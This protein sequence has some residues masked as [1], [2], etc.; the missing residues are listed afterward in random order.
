MADV[1][2]SIQLAASVGMS[3]NPED[4]ILTMGEIAMKEAL[5]QL[6]TFLRAPGGE[7]LLELEKKLVRLFAYLSGALIAFTVQTLSRPDGSTA[8]PIARV[9]DGGSWRHKGFR[10][11]KVRFL[12]GFVCRIHTPYLVQ[13]HQGRKRGVGRRGR[14][15]GGCY[16]E[17][18]ALGIRYG[19]SPGLQSAIA[20]Q[21]VRGASFEETREV[22]FEQGDAMNVKTIRRIALAVADG[23]ITQRQARIEAAG[24]EA[25]HTNEFTGQRVVIG[26][27]GGRVRI[28]EGGDRGRRRANGRRGFHAQWREPKLFSVHVIDDDGR[29]VRHLQPLYE[30]TM[31]GPGKTFELLVAEMKLRGISKVKEVIIV[32]DG[33]SWIWNRT[34]ELPS[35]L[36]VPEEKVTR[37]ADLYHAVEHLHSAAQS[38]S[39]W[40][41][42]DVQRWVKIRKRFLLQ[43]RVD[44]VI[45]DMRSLR[46]GRNRRVIRRE[47]AYFQRL[48]PFMR[49]RFYKAHAIPL[50]SGATESA[51]RRVVNLRLKG[52]GIFW[53]RATAEMMLHLRA[54]L[55][56]RRWDE[57]MARVINATPHGRPGFVS[58]SIW[59]LEAAA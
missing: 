6:R 30:A 35:L 31:Q 28:R 46:K 25:V 4:A 8:R 20:R 27:D 10:D 49:Y 14:A 58:E 54:Y 15:G 3:A 18:E 34:A 12:G 47:S 38:R 40:A 1:Y 24:A 45:A 50:G 11:T 17:L 29:P 53:K 2:P 22:F 42:D 9:S 51:I 41:L 13:L 26:V 23:A 55:K 37:V 16:P 21:A 48:A 43:G 56:A 32:A 39:D 19:A 44:R 59:P 7:S 57:L 5:D 36:G 52:N 33:A